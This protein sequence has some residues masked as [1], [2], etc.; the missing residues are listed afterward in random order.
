M[1]DGESFDEF[2]AR[3]ATLNR[4]AMASANL[5]DHATEA[6]TRDMDASSEGG[7]ITRDRSNS[8]YVSLGR[9]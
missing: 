3:S 1:A 9:K 4:T 2:V 8:V 5:A 6:D 7:G